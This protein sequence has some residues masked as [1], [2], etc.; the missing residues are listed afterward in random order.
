M[1][2]DY[3]LCLAAII[4]MIVFLGGKWEGHE[5]EVWV[6]ESKEFRGWYALDWQVE[7]CAQYEVDL[8]EYLEK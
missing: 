6:S 8:S 5:C 2:L 3:I 7:Q 1:L 4:A